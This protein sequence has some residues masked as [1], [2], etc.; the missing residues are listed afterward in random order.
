M[1]VIVLTTGILDRLQQFLSSRHTVCL[2][3]WR[4]GPL[5]KIPCDQCMQFCTESIFCHNGL[6]SRTEATVAIPKLSYHDGA[7]AKMS[8][9]K[10][11]V[12]T[13]ALAVI[14]FIIKIRSF[15]LAEPHILFIRDWTNSSFLYIL[16]GRPGESVNEKGESYS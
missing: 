10:S 11:G 8:V 15:D 6:S 2:E 13:A 1:L 3:R 5:A 7:M 12:I 9:C 14:C 4:L 16:P